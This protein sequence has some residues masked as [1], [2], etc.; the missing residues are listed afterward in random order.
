MTETR[1]PSCPD[2]QS[3][4]LALEAGG[5]GVWSWDIK[6]DDVTWIG[7]LAEIH[8]IKTESWTGTFSTFQQ[9]IHPEDQPEVMAAIKESLRN[10]KP[11]QV[12]VSPRAAGRAGRPLDRGDGFGGRTRRRGRASGSAAAAT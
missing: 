5:V 12:R 2:V 10:R 6:T 3:M 11:Y 8:G 9:V 4:G 1:A 7:K